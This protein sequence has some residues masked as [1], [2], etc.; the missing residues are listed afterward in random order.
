MVERYTSSAYGVVTVRAAAPW[1]AISG[2]VSQE[3]NKDSLYSLR[4][5]LTRVLGN[6][7]RYDER[8]EVS[9]ESTAEWDLA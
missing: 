9:K 6:R 1:D 3:D 4:E 5:S 8:A 2:N 7:N